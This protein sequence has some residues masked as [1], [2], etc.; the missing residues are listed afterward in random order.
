[1]AIPNALAQYLAELFGQS[2]GTLPPPLP[3]IIV[4]GLEQNQFSINPS[5]PNGPVSPGA[6]NDD[7]QSAFL[8]NIGLGVGGPA[9]T[10]IAAG[11][12][13]GDQENW[14]NAFFAWYQLFVASASGI[15]LDRLG[16][17]LGINRPP[18]TGMSD[19]LY[20]Q[21][22]IK[23]TAHKLT[24]EAFLELLEI[25]YGPDSC[26]AY[27][28]SG[29]SEPYVVSAGDTLQFD[30][31]GQFPIVC[32]FHSNDFAI[33]GTA[34]AIE[35][36]A[37]ITH[38]MRQAGLLGGYCIPFVDP[39][40]GLTV[41]KIASASLGL[42]SSVQVTGGNAQNAFQFSTLI[43]EADVAGTWSVTIPA[44]GVAR[45]TTSGTTTVNLSIVEE[46]DY[47]NIFGAN[48]AGVNHG[49]FPIL[50]VVT[51]YVLGVFTQYFD[52]PNVIAIAQGPI[53]I[54]AASDIIWFR[55]TRETTQQA[56]SREVIVSQHG[57]TQVDVLLPATSQAVTRQLLTA[58]Y[59]QP[60]TGEAVTNGIR[61]GNG[62]VT[63]TVASNSL[64]AGEQILVDGFYSDTQAPV[65]AS[66][67]GS[68]SG[69]SDSCLQS[70][71]DRTAAWASGAGQNVQGVILNNGKAFWCGGDE[72]GMALDSSNLMEI[73]GHTTRPDGSIAN[74]YTLTAGPTLADSRTW[75][76]TVTLTVGPNIHK[77]L[78]IGGLDFVG[79]T[80]LNSCE[81]Y[82]PVG[83]TV[84]LSGN[85]GTGREGHAAIVLTDGRVLVSGG[86]T[87][88]YATPAGITSCEVYDPSVG[89]WSATG[90]MNHAHTFHKMVTLANGKVMAVG[91]IETTG[92]M[93]TY[94]EIFDPAANTWSL[95]GG[96]NIPRIGMG[97]TVL[98]DGRVVVF[99]GTTTVG[100][101]SA[102]DLAANSIEIWSPT[103]GRWSA[104]A[105]SAPINPLPSG[106]FGGF[107]VV[108]V[109]GRSQ[110]LIP[111]VYVGGL[112]TSCMIF[113]LVGMRTVGIV[114]T[115]GQQPQANLVGPFSDGSI[116]YVGDTTFTAYNLYFYKAGADFVGAGGI[117]GLQTLTAATSTTLTFSTPAFPFYALNAS[118]DCMVYDAKQ[119]ARIY[120]GPYAFDQT[121]GFAV[122][123]TASTTTAQLNKNTSYTSVTLVNGKD[124]PDAPGF[125]VIGLGYDYEAGPVRYL[126]KLDSNTLSLDFRNQ[127]SVDIPS[128]ADVTLLGF[129]GP[130]TL[131]QPDHGSFFITGSAAGR[132]AAEAAILD[133][134][135]AG[136][137]V[138][139]TIRYPGDRGLGHEGFPDSGSPAI[140]DIVEVFA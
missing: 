58:A 106:Q 1:M 27:I 15:Y 6:S 140:S 66:N 77:V 55:P 86:T 70:H 122:T 80:Y 52:V 43:E 138:N 135:A 21:L 50:N 44:A 38:A 11:I 20:R 34:T 72:A 19:D 95:T 65:T 13:T 111:N 14:D 118:A 54:A 10:A 9:W 62:L 39:L 91:G 12:G 33:P 17:G 97:V 16:S 130:Y 68:P 59:L 36:A 56:S 71:L 115:S 108:P 35:V 18:N 102:G 99:G 121:G 30:I 22:I 2:G 105:T 67:F 79:P 125:L 128:G 40:T 139:I 126:G 85:L 84:V 101:T 123:A 114:P 3:N 88:A 61:D 63:L 117:N 83:N 87:A 127:F 124:F 104:I 31:D 132:V 112:N 116:L 92:V 120:P 110:V 45:F 109:Q 49:S 131:N 48:F 57:E 8:K 26:R 133:I 4:P 7:A 53:S 42:G 129:R 41:L 113:D 23:K 51:T 107:N 5:S 89:T 98:T 32:T 24:E 82:D 37:A 136:V 76:Q 137:T 119:L 64:V 134:A 73:T 69:I 94:V 28:V 90:S 93:S 75:H 81:L 96:L 46:G 60:T 29:L 47:V 25:F 103:T 78:I 100:G 74:N